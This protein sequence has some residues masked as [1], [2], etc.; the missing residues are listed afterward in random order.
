MNIFPVYSNVRVINRKPDRF[1][2]FEPVGFYLILHRLIQN[3]YLQLTKTQP[4]VVR[5]K[6]YRELNCSS[7]FQYCAAS[8]SALQYHKKPCQYPRPGLLQVPV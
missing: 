5:N 1:N 8:L 6:R 7:Y 4:V 3:P 2:P